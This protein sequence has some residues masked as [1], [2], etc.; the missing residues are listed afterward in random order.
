M[1][2]FLL[3]RTVAGAVTIIALSVVVFAATQI[4]PGDV[5]TAVL[6]KDATPDAVAKI[7]EDLDLNRP[8]PERYLEWFTGILQGDLGISL[9]ASASA[10]LGDS[11]V[12]GVPVGEV[13]GSSISYSLVLA[14]LTTILLVPLSIILGVWTAMRRGRLPD[15]SVSGFTLIL[16]SLPEFVVATVLILGVAVVW[17]V[18]PAV[19]LIDESRPLTQQSEVLVLPVLTLLA[20][21]LAQ[22][23]RMLRASVL[24]VLD[25]DYVEMARLKGLSGLAIMRRYVL[26]NALGPT[27]QVD[28]INVAWL[29]GGIV[30]VEAVFQYPGIGLALVNAV[31]TRDVPTVQTISLFI[32]VMYVVLN[33]VADV[34]SVLLT[35]K[36]RTTL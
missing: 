30:V 28:A 11:D 36:L 16:I 24:D 18:L 34:A 31:S 2:R 5:A 4:L 25:A 8:A 29:I 32:A 26:P 20:A 9:T 1:I 15:L 12:P 10:N 35:P 19:S 23:T 3:L 21:T 27:I 7:R 33:L 17:G 6:G 14:A 13:I 22:T